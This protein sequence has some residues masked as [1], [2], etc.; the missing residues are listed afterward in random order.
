MNS[1]ISKKDIK[2]AYLETGLKPLT[3]TWIHIKEGKA[4]GACAMTTLF[5]HKNGYCPA[6]AEPVKNWA[7]TQFGTDYF[8]GFLDGWDRAIA[9]SHRDK[10]ERYKEGWSDG[11]AALAEIFK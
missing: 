7:L 9:T 4:C 3:S 11:I 1:R 2:I 5:T 6:T 10:N 8:A